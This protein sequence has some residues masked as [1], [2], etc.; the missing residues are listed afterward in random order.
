MKT[1]ALIWLTTTEAA[2]RTQRHPDTV[3][4]ALEAGEL[5]GGQGKTRGRWRIHVDCVDA[6]ALGEQCAHQVAA[7]AS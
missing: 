3:R 2:A 5:H 4:R 7:K 6:W 1:G